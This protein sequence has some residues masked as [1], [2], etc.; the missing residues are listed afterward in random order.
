M[1]AHNNGLGNFPESEIGNECGMLDLF[2][3]VKNIT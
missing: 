3:P 2:S 1:S